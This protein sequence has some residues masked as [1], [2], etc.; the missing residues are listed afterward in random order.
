MLL[1]CGRRERVADSLPAPAFPFARLELRGGHM[2]QLTRGALDWLNDHEGAITLAALDAAGINR[3]QTR[4][5]VER[6]V[7]ERVLNGVYVL[8]GTPTR[9]MTRNVA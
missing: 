7:L 1:M 9:E 4:R 5:L 3:H 2:A 6:R 8:G